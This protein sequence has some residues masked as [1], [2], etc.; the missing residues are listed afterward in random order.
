[1]WP[2]MLDCHLQLSK[3]HAKLVS[4]QGSHFLLKVYSNHSVSSCHRVFYQC[5][6]L[7]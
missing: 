4:R 2:K 1:M 3:T 5:A 7:C 6:K